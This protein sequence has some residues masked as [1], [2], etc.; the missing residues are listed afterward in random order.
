ML[1]DPIGFKSNWEWT[2]S[3]STYHFDNNVQDK[4]GD[5]FWPLGRFEGD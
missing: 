5:Y 3:N 1:E 2:K 4:L